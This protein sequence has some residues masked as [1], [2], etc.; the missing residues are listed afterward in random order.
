MKNDGEIE[1]EEMAKADAEIPRNRRYG[2]LCIPWGLTIVATFPGIIYP[3]FFPAGLYRLF[4]VPETYSMD[5]G[6]LILAGW[7]V[8]IWLTFVASICKGKLS[9]F[10]FYSV[11][12]VLLALNSVGCRLFWSDFSHIH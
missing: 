3:R 11:L 4:G 10:I 7:A 8:Y 6:G 5:R 9:Y 1:A 12:C 2:L